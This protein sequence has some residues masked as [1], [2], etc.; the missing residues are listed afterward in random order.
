MSTPPYQTRRR[1]LGVAVLAVL[2]GLFGLLTLLGG[3]LLLVGVAAGAL[4]SIP[5]LF[6]VGGL[7]AGAI[8]FIIGLVLLAVAYGLWDLRMWALALAVL[9]LIFYLVVYG[10]AGAFVSVGFLLSLL[11]LV[12]LIA[13]R[14]HF[15]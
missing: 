14:R 8:F 10:V 12:Y 15:S 13:V 11:L 9:V 2:I 1:P 4:P 5:L 3:L 7:T 6:G